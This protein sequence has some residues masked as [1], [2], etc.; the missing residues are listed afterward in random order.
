MPLHHDAFASAI[1]VDAAMAMAWSLACKHMPPAIPST[2][3]RTRRP[4][5]QVIS[6]SKCITYATSNN[7]GAHVRQVVVA[8]ARALG[9]LLRKAGAD[10]L[11]GK[12]ML[13]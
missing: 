13:K 6:T 2:D 8:A 3:I 7:I 11:H 9:Y 1:A 5:T 12:R 10:E 4:Q